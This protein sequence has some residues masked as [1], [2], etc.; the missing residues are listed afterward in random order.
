MTFSKYIS[1]SMSYVNGRM[2]RF[3]SYLL[4]LSGSLGL[5]HGQDVA[6][7]VEGRN[8]I[9]E[10]VI[11]QESPKSETVWAGVKF[12]IKP[13]W[14]IYSNVESDTGLP[15]TL[16]WTLPEGLSAGETL[17]PESTR[18]E[19]EGFVDFIYEDEVILWAKLTVTDPSLLE[20][21]PH[22]IRV[23]AEWLECKTM[24]IP[25]SGEMS[26][27]W[28]PKVDYTHSDLAASIQEVTTF[29]NGAS[30]DPLK[31]SSAGSNFL[32]LIAFA[33]VGGLILNL[34]PCV[35]PVIGLK[36]M[37]FVEQAG[38]D[39]RKIMVHGLTF[40]SGVVVSFWVLSGLLLILRASGQQLGWGFQLQEP[41]FNYALILLLFG[42][43]LS[44]NGVFEFGM[45]MI[46]MGSKLSN[47]DGMSGSF[48][49]GV[50]AT[51][52]ATPCSAPFLAPALGAALAL[53][54][55]Q[56]LILFTVI[57]LGLSTPYL[58]LS[59]FP[60]VL[61]KMP[62]PGAWMETFKQFMAFPLYATVA[63]L[64]WSLFGQIDEGNQFNL[65]L[66]LVLIGMG[67]WIF[68]R[69]SS[70]VKSKNT[71][72]FGAAVAL[73]VIVGG[74]VLG[75]PRDKDDFWQPWSPEVVKQH[76]TEEKTV[77]VDFTARWCATCQANKKIV[78]GN[79]D[80]LDTFE[81]KGVVALKA[82]WTNR[83][84]RITRRLEELGKAAVPVNLVYKDGSL[85]PQI[86]PELLNPQLVL[87][88]IE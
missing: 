19:N 87:E 10:M 37:G 4:V 2:S 84:D 27:N 61:N 71:R 85:E 55:V 13:E 41:W 63:Y 51:V 70:P 79:Q 3:V 28:D 6:H 88:A 65:L 66:G 57:G 64:V 73:L 18:Y 46:G 29:V 23:F 69:W 44:L 58:L 67:L 16:T 53:S 50:M 82:D 47:K 80:V 52:V 86:L 9:S 25:G 40:T 83:D 43:A 68:G 77:Y 45:S 5:L 24:C 17:Y 26:I 48:L 81:E 39:S 36:I 12:E 76:V 34:M 33:F 15:T 49:S 8:V 22:Q 60:S 72:R 7:R 30:T 59:M 32:A 20:S 38:Q 75:H 54:P 42:F 35:F 11:Y 78:F 31:E 21:G 74:V 62:R 1:N 56:S 14:H